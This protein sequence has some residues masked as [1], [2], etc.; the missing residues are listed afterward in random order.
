[1]CTYFVYYS[2]CGEVDPSKPLDSASLVGEILKIVGYVVLLDDPT[3]PYN[4][5]KMC[6]AMG[7]TSKGHKHVDKLAMEI[8]KIRSMSKDKK[9]CLEFRF[10]ELEKKLES[11]SWDEQEKVGDERQRFFSRCK[12]SMTLRTPEGIDLG[13]DRINN[14]KNYSLEMCRRAFK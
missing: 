13:Q 11:I 5:H 9:K 12:Y 14:F 4:V 6:E 2:L 7:D 10:E 3:A 1:L 8:K